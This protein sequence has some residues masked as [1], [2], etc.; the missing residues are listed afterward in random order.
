MNVVTSSP[1]LVSTGTDVAHVAKELIVSTTS[2]LCASQSSRS[3]SVVQG[4]KKI[5][6]RFRPCRYIP[7]KKVLLSKY[8]P[9]TLSKG[10]NPQNVPAETPKAHFSGFI[11]ILFAR[12]LSKTRSSTAM[13]V[14]LPFAWLH[15]YIVDANAPRSLCASCLGIWWSWLADM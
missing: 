15:H 7:L 1:A 14:I 5:Q 11:F 8:T 9:E 2:S 10:I 13:C 4:R 12:H 3:V 6:Q